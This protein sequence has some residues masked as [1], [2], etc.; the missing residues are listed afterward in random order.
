MTPQERH[1]VMENLEQWKH[2]TPEEKLRIEKKY[3]SWS[4]LTPKQK[5]HARLEHEKQ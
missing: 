1:K 2:M 4:R 3:N 5:E